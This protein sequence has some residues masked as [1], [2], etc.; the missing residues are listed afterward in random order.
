MKRLIDTDICV[1]LIN[2]RSEQA[3][4]RFT[5]FDAG[6]LGLSAISVAELMFGANNSRRIQENLE[7]LRYFLMP[8]ITV[9]FDAKAAEVYGT[10]RVDLKRKGTPIGPLDTMIA[11]QA[12]SLDVPLVTNN[13]REFRRVE[14]L[15]VENWAT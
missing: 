13:V 4:R 11:A 7:A 10:L 2:G 1:Y 15:E 9:E 6:D 14:G 5:R 12:L 8:L 3:L